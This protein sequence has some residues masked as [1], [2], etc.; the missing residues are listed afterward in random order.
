MTNINQKVWRIIDIDSA[1]KKNLLEGLI[2]TS[3]LARKIAKEHDLVDN[4]DAVISAIDDTNGYIDYTTDS[5]EDELAVDMV[6]YN[7]TQAKQATISAINTGTN[8]ITVDV[9][10]NI[11]GWVATDE[12]AVYGPLFTSNIDSIAAAVITYGADPL[13]GESN[14]ANGQ[15]L[16]NI[17]KKAIATIDSFNAGA[18]TITVTDED[19]IEGWDDTDVICVMA[20]YFEAT[21]D[22]DAGVTI[23]YSSPI[24]ERVD[25]N[26]C[27]F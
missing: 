23:T 4:V 3:A 26:N 11:T 25:K 1:I 7:S 17:S 12:I 22:S 16:C 19:H 18:N 8:R 5:G 14:L 6:V 27:L 20:P 24:G 2:N 9:P 15:T 21:F 10:S 13:I